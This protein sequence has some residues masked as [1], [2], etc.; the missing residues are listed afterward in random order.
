MLLRLSVVANRTV[1]LSDGQIALIRETNLKAATVP[2]SSNTSNIEY[3]LIRGPRVATLFLGYVC[4]RNL[5]KI[6][7]KTIIT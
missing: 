1:E 5:S 2:L 6:H 7:F 4:P 3:K